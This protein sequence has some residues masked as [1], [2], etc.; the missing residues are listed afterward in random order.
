MKCDTT[1]ESRDIFSSTW[2]TV[3]LFLV[4]AIAIGVTGGSDF[5]SSWRTVVWTA[6]LGIMGTACIANAVRCGRLHCYVT[7]PFF[8]ALAVVTLL[9]GLG[10][11]PLG[12]NGWSLIG[13][14][15][16]IGAIVLCCVPEMLFGKYR[17]GSAKNG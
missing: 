17:R 3:V 14:A 12:R 2:L 10:V 9:Y 7:G 15:I 8:L 16:L 4:P 1:G 13:L 11:V 6:A 5:G